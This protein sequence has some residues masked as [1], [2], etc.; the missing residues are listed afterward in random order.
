MLQQIVKVS[1]IRLESPKIP[2]RIYSYCR[3]QLGYVL[4]LVTKGLLSIKKYKINSS[5]GLGVPDSDLKRNSR[6]YSIICY[7]DSFSDLI[8]NGQDEEDYPSVERSYYLL[9]QLTLKGLESL[10]YEASFDVQNC[11]KCG[12]SLLQMLDNAKEYLQE[13]VNG[14]HLTKNVIILAFIS[15]D[16]SRC[17][18]TYFEYPFEGEAQAL[19]YKMMGGYRRVHMF[20]KPFNVSFYEKILSN[21][22]NVKLNLY[23]GYE[24]SNKV[25]L[26]TLVPYSYI[27]SWMESKP[28]QLSGMIAKDKIVGVARGRVEFGSRALGNRSILANALNKSMQ[29]KLNLEI[30]LRES[31][32]PFVP[33]VME[34]DC[35]KYFDC[36]GKSPFMLLTVRVHGYNVETRKQDLSSFEKYHFDSIC[37]LD[38]T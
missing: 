13:F 37:Q 31:F 38:S 9:K 22:K 34:E 33:I 18:F 25:A 36:D 32:R 27:L 21:A 12:R 24:I 15:F 11:S 4:E 8:G 14:S 3:N 17:P 29:T 2:G 5:R 1:D 26:H 10:S 28:L 23:L 30:K 7:G 20:S 19:C 6:H 35:P 16:I